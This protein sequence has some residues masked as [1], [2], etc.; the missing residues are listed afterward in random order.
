MLFGGISRYFSSP[1]LVSFSRQKTLTWVWYSESAIT[2]SYLN[3]KHK[4]VK[5][6]MRP[7]IWPIAPRPSITVV[8]SMF[9]LALQKKVM[10]TLY[11]V[12][13]SCVKVIGRTLRHVPY[14]TISFCSL[15]GL[16]L[17]GVI[18]SISLVELWPASFVQQNVAADLTQQEM[19]FPFVFSHFW[20]KFRVMLKVINE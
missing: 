5:H 19:A 11:F 9:S 14:P 17:Y 4:A 8:L 16:R 18:G 10:Q 13:R 15:I 12:C 2:V 7:E 20:F 1:F 3:V 6:S